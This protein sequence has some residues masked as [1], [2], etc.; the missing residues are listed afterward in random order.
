[1][2][3]L[4]HNLY[5]DEAIPYT[6]DGV[7]ADECYDSTGKKQT[8]PYIL[9]DGFNTFD[10]N[11]W[12]CLSGDYRGIVYL[13]ASYQGN[14]FTELGHLVVKAIKNN[15]SSGFEWSS[16]FVN[17]DGKFEFQYGTV[18]ARIR[19]PKGA[20]NYHATLWMLG[21][22]PGEIDIA[23]A[24]NGTV[25][26]AVHYYD[27]SGANWHSKLVASFSN[28]DPKEFNEYRLDWQE[29]RIVFSVNGVTAGSF[30]VNEATMS[31]FN[32]FRQKM[33]LIVNLLPYSTS[34]K[35]YDD[36][37]AVKME[38]DYIKVIKL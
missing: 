36:G 31:G 28:I 13:P 37:S 2:I 7:P 23:E 21:D 33:Y 1:M 29:N 5:G 34:S 3:L 18:L 10:S 9:S 26:A 4:P 24:D 27:Q 8:I 11:I 6:T 12:S 25:H 17:S 14:A 15:P 35:K 19:F 20:T 30:D 38:V 16:A 22:S 32:S